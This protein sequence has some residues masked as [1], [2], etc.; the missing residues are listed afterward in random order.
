MAHFGE[1][2]DLSEALALLS[3]TE[4]FISRV[5]ST[6]FVSTLSRTLHLIGLL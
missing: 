1:L 6:Q 5:Y 4:V 2:D 3:D